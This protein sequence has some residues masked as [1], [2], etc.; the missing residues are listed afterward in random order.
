[1]L[2]RQPGLLGFSL[3]RRRGA[4]DDH[5]GRTIMP[6]RRWAT[7]QAWSA[8]RAGRRAGART[9]VATGHAHFRV[10]WM[11]GAASARLLGR[12]GLR[13]SERGRR[14]RRRRRRLGSNA[15][16]ARDATGRWGN[17]DAPLSAGADGDLGRWC[18]AQGAC[19]RRAARGRAGAAALESL[20]FSWDAPSD[21][22]DVHLA[23]PAEWYAGS[24]KASAASP[25]ERRRAT[26]PKK[27]APD[28]ALGGWVAAVRR[29]RR[30]R[31]AARAAELD[32][33]GFA[34]ASSRQCGSAFMRSSRGARIP[35]AST[36]TPTP[37]ACSATGT[38]SRWC[39]ATAALRRDGKISSKR[40]AYLDELGIGA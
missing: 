20:G 2:P 27:H 29:R 6:R 17:A 4:L 8:W 10:A 28:P 34:W 21:A 11:D 37:R 9:R 39:E 30:A 35:P 32:A 19:A 24:A 15:R 26:C 25:A 23:P 7:E 36:A 33:V 18:K 40:L 12:A 5:E 31:R 16:A 22:D 3:L 14:A 38:S 1:M 13:A